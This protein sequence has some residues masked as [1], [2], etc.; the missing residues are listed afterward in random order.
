MRADKNSSVNV[1]G[2][3]LRFLYGSRLVRD[4]SSTHQAK[5]LWT[6]SSNL[7]EAEIVKPV[8]KNFFHFSK[9]QKNQS[10]FLPTG[11]LE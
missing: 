8:S 7:P 1:E 2:T 9:K 6:A 11:F 4:A 3:I 10:E 5:C